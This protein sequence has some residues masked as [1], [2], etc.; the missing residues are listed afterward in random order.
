[1]LS[2]H[3]VENRATVLV[4]DDSPEMRRYLRFLLELDS[5]HVE[6]ASTGDEAVQR[7]RNGFVPQIVLLDLQMPGMD[8]LKT[9]RH[10]RKLR[11][12]LKVIMCSGV[13][14]ARKIR[15]AASL[16]AEAYIRKPV[17]KLYLSAAMERCLSRGLEPASELG[18][19]GTLLMYPPP[20][21]NT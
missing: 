6:T 3:R 8:G 21:Y 9:L 19:R 12:S 5:Y 17:Q 7:L 15:R 1:M 16:G 4:V 18:R 2:G 11:P 14:D 10:L 20:R 13:E